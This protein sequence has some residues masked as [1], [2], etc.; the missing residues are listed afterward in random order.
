MAFGKK[1]S[2]DE[3]LIIGVEE[4]TP[5]D[6]GIGEAIDSEL[7]AAEPAADAAEVEQAEAT[8]EEAPVAAAE[9]LPGAAD[10]L[11]S[12]PDLLSMFQTTTIESDDK[13]ALLELAGEVEID[14]LLEDL[15]TVQAAL[16]SRR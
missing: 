1:K 2:K 15:Q 9:P 16:K 7:F 3:P 11:A 4:A 13:A 12:G 6:D 8:V 10:P 14:D 5:V